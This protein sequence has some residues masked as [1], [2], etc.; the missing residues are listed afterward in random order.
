MQQHNKK[1]HPLH[2]GIWVLAM[3]AGM[4]GVVAEQ[5]SQKPADQGAPFAQ[6]YA[7]G[8]DQNVKLIAPP[9]IEDRKQGFASMPGYEGTPDAATFTWDG[10]AAKWNPSGGTKTMDVGQVFRV[11]AGI[12]PQEMEMP[13]RLFATPVPG[14]WIYREDASPAQKMLD[15][16]KAMQAVLGDG[17]TLREE[18]IQRQAIVVRGKLSFTQPLVANQPAHIVQLYQGSTPP[19][20]GTN[21][22]LARSPAVML[23]VI[24]EITGHPVVVEAELDQTKLVRVAMNNLSERVR[25]VD[26]MDRAA[27]EDVLKH[28]SEQTSLQFV[29]EGRLLPTWRLVKAGAQ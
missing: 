2:S 12:W 18:T 3:L 10:K 27:I 4:S 11:I 14:D 25:A 7:L 9:F 16:G 29:I 8:A 21:F 6:V 22:T 17:M 1:V 28:V 20:S 13:R 5:T 19:R 15:L 26:V 23:H 24:G